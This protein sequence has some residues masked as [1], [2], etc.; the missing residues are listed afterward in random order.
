[1]P[2]HARLLGGFEIQTSERTV[3]RF[4]TAK[5]RELLAYLCFYRR[6][7][8]TR[9]ELA[10]R[11]WPEADPEAGRQSLRMALSDIRKEAGPDLLRTGRE[12]V[13]IG[14]A[15]R[16]DVEELFQAVRTGDWTGLPS[17]IGPLLPGFFG[18]WIPAEQAQLMATV[19]RAWKATRASELA[20]IGERIDSGPSPRERVAPPGTLFIGREEELDSLRRRFQRGRLATILGL[21]GLG[22]TRLAQEYAARVSDEVVFVDW[23]RRTAAEFWSA[24]AEA[25]GL[26][27][28]V[29][30]TRRQV[31]EYLRDRP[32]LLVLDNLETILPEATDSLAELLRRTDAPTF[33]ATSRVAVGIPEESCLL[34][35]P[36]DE[37]DAEA[38]LRDRAQYASPEAELS[39]AWV[40]D[41][42]EKTGGIP[43]AIEVVAAQL[44]AI[45]A[46]VLQTRAPVAIQ[47]SV[48]IAVESAWTRLRTSDRA[49]LAALSIL[50]SEFDFEIAATTTGVESM[51]AM[52]RLLRSGLVTRRDER[53]TL[54]EPVR[55]RVLGRLPTA[56]DE[57]HDRLEVAAL[58]W[59]RTAEAGYFSAEEPEVVRQV[60]ARTSLFRQV[61][62]RLIEHRRPEA[63]VMVR[64]LA[65]AWCR[66]SDL[67]GWASVARE[68]ESITEHALASYAVSLLANFSG[69]PALARAA[70][71]RGFANRPEALRP[72]LTPFLDEALGNALGQLGDFEGAHLHLARSVELHRRAPDSRYVPGALG[73]RGFLFT[74]QGQP[75]AAIPYLEETMGLYRDLGY[76]WGQA[77]T[78]NKLAA[79][80]LLLDEPAKSLRYQER[81]L[82][83]KETLGDRRSY[84]LGLIERG[85]A[86]IRLE[87]FDLARKS[88]RE[89]IA[90]FDE[91]GDEYGL[92]RAAKI[93]SLLAREPAERWLAV[94][95]AERLEARTQADEE[96]ARDPESPAS[97]LARLL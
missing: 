82:A 19:Q 59:T 86:A 47:E 56:E 78:L 97:R 60:Y 62:A 91:V 85:A 65:W 64:G 8:H 1:M 7:A 96:M 80:M 36:I 46:D 3:T 38:L 63:A 51:E 16:T 22:K 39:A 69:R 89:G 25:L 21:G 4:R 41:V 42:C 12:T 66:R 18:D 68:V 32:H 40:A 45:P 44:E 23:S 34:L 71:L 48:A 79:A 53:Y 24:L 57:A 26:L 17:D 37:S 6:R 28:M 15:V 43:L 90:I 49:H 13:E 61:I 35:G 92:A 84:G 50:P 29:V 33:L 72:D 11:F 20:Q 77:A 54:L 94:S 9:E 10:E 95:I 2:L 52:R 14:A 73:V 55:D 75:A 31:L 74:Q 76:L 5:T 88:L 30:H 27:G 87:E 70:A 67:T 81:S 58:A 83:I 93:V